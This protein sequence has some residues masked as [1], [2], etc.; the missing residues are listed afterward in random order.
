ML[1]THEITFH[2]RRPSLLHPCEMLLQHSGNHS[3]SLSVTEQSKEHKITLIFIICRAAIVCFTHMQARSN[4]P[5]YD[6]RDKNF[7]LQCCAYFPLQLVRVLTLLLPPPPPPPL[8]LVHAQSVPQ[9]S[10]LG[11]HASANRFSCLINITN[12][13]Y[14]NFVHFVK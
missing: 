2:H 6:L 5:P 14:N 13:L 3:A 8:A 9:S 12:H 1:I 11:A 7:A 4:A 10:V